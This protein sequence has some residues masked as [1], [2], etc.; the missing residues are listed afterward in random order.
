MVRQFPLDWKKRRVIA[1]DLDGTLT[2][3]KSPLDA[4]GARSLA[5]LL[6]RKKVAV[7]SGGTFARFRAQIIRPLRRFGGAGVRFQNL[8]LFPTTAMSFYRYR[9]GWRKVYERTFSAAERRTILAALQRA[10][11]MERYRPRRTYGRLIEDRGTEVTFSA[12]GQRAPLSKKRRWNRGR[13]MRPELL[14]LLKR[15]LPGYKEEMGGLTSIDVTKKGVDKA[16]GMREI[17]RYLR[18]RPCEILFVGDALY[19][20]GNDSPVLRTGVAHCAVKG[21]RETGRLIDFLVAE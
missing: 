1:F 18:V 10:L 21:P 17:E 14:K 15:I 8:F 5:A 9:G 7:V 4:A 3:S 12:L 6:A 19:R 2:A 11:E 20:G 13:D 16:Y